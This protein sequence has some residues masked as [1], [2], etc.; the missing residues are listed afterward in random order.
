MLYFP[1]D[2]H[3]FEVRTFL[4]ILW[5]LRF[6]W[7]QHPAARRESAASTPFHV[8]FQRHFKVCITV[9]RSANY[10]MS[11]K[12]LKRE[13]FRLVWPW[14][15]DVFWPI[16]PVVTV[17]GEVSKLNLSLQVFFWS[18][19]SSREKCPVLQ[20]LK[21]KTTCF[22]I[23]PKNRPSVLVH[24][25]LTCTAWLHRVKIIMKSISLRRSGD[26]AINADPKTDETIT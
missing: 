15:L 24:C 17:P 5:G 1:V 6:L 7:S 4:W 26:F 11:H 2:E 21:C 19:P 25:H 12:Y 18:S 3:D 14:S 9:C 20:T 23:S 8:C 16:N 22:F 10:L 13:T